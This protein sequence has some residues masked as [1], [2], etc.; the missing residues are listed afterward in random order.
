MTELDEKL[1][2]IRTHAEDVL[3]LEKYRFSKPT[4]ILLLARRVLV[5]VKTVC[6][7]RREVSMPLDW[8][9]SYLKKFDRKLLALFGEAESEGT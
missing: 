5:L 2:E 9:E 1:A 3:A 7:L 4:D 6:E 8:P